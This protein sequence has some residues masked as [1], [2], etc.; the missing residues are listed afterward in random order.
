MKHKGFSLVELLI[1]IA[2][3]GIIAAIAIPSLLATRRAANEGSAQSSL[4][5]IF[6]AQ[7][8][9]Q[10]TYGNGQFAQT[11]WQLADVNLIDQY[12]GQGSKNE[13]NFTIMGWRNVAGAEAQFVAEGWPQV[14][15]L[16]NGGR[17]V[18]CITEDGVMRSQQGS[19]Q[20]FGEGQL[21]RMAPIQ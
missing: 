10:A 17:R 12:L 6:S 8:T 21:R 11:T 16:L 13:Y 3:I 20:I 9:Y 14:G 15:Y 5:T 4:R 1:V 2:L 7:I 18:F 19:E